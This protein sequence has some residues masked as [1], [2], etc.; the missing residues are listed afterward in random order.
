MLCDI[1][2]SVVDGSKNHYDVYLLWNL[3][4]LLRLRDTG[5]K[6]RN[7]LKNLLQSNYKVILTWLFDDLDITFYSTLPLFKNN[8]NLLEKLDLI[9][10]LT[11][12]QFLLS[13]DWYV[14]FDH[15]VLT[16]QLDFSV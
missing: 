13:L 11:V 14:K 10:I 4:K 3:L 7:N 5:S 15:D 8:S 1:I 16:S 6:L 2:T 12:K 9:V